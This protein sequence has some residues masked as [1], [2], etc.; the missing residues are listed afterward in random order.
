MR[1]NGSRN[2]LNEFLINIG[3]SEMSK[4]MIEFANS[5]NGLN[6]IDD[7][8]DLDKKF[9]KYFKRNNDTKK[10]SRTSSEI[11]ESKTF[12]G[13]SDIGLAI[14]PILRYKGIPTVYVESAK[15]SWINNMEQRCME[16]HIFLE[17]FINNKW[18]LYDPTFRCVYSDYDYNNPCLP[19]EY[20]VF[21]KAL[22][23]HELNVF[24]VNSERNLAKSFFENNQVIY[25]EPDYK[26]IKLFII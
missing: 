6:D 13:C 8:K 9:Y 10:F 3:Q 15:M 16:G 25:D 12:S 21:A 7:F 26:K 11:F 24:D 20:Y 2:N 19:R 23:C 18:Y 4:Q 14:A 5:I 22:N 17:I 1:Y